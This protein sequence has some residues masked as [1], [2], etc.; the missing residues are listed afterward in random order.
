MLITYYNSFATVFF[1][2]R[3]R[4]MCVSLYIW[5][6]YR[7]SGDGWTYRLLMPEN[8]NVQTVH[9]HHIVPS[10]ALISLND[11]NTHLYYYSVTIIIA[12]RF[13]H[14]E[15]SFLFFVHNILCL[16]VSHPELM[17]FIRKVKSNHSF[18]H[19]FLCKQSKWVANYIGFIIIY[20]GDTFF[21]SLC[22]CL[23]VRP[24]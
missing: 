18:C 7:L 1:I 2:V 9:T 3:T 24:T 6:T 21:C 11:P 22:L 10:H 17:L 19:S 8:Q 4:F 14:I 23:Y 13:A 20:N 5:L 15:S 16:I 12:L